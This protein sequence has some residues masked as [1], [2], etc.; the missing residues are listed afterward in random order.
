MKRNNIVQSQS[1]LTSAQPISE[2]LG[3]FRESEDNLK[4]EETSDTAAKS[5]DNLS[6]TELLKE[7]DTKIKSIYVPFSIPPV[8]SSLV[9]QSN[10]TCNER[11]TNSKVK[12][13]KRKWKS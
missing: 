13:M 11:E 7:A 9:V 12:R 4:D 3:D 10:L 6:S 5:T 1:S 2:S 8:R